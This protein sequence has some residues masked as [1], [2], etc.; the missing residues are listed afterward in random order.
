[1]R[2]RMPN[3][4]RVEGGL[5]RRALYLNVPPGEIAQMCRH[6]QVAGQEPDCQPDPN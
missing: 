1:M 2:S 5:L 3:H 6:A 4:K